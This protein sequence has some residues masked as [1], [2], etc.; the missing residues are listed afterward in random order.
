[1]AKPPGMLNY[2]TRIHH[3]VTTGEC[4][5]LLARAG[6]AAVSIEFEAGTGLP[7]GIGFR[8]NTPHGPRHFTMP[9]QIDGVHQTLTQANREGKLRSD[10]H[11]S[12]SLASREQATN[13]AWRVMK[14]WLEASLARIAAG[15]AELSEVM[16]P[17]LNVDDSRT[18]WQAYQAREQAALTAGGGDG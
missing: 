15:M 13:V 1:M 7:N 2:T 8:L 4:V 16:L 3:G 10:G 14:D 5:S 6:A 11:R 17:Y 12:A 18:L 9:V